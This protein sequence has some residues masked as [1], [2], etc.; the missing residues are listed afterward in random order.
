MAARL[1]GRP[2]SP[3]SNPHVVT[4]HRCGDQELRDV[5]AAAW[6]KR[7]VVSP[8]RRSATTACWSRCAS[9][10]PPERW[11]ARA[12]AAPGRGVDGR[13]RGIDHHS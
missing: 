2:L 5:A 6:A 4:F 8:G 9:K 10:I 1:L 11:R 13:G 3:P 7:R 12:P